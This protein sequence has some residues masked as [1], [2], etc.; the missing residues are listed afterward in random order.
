MKHVINCLSCFQRSPVMYLYQ[1]FFSQMFGSLGS[2]AGIWSVVNVPVWKNANSPAPF[3]FTRVG[4]GRK[5]NDQ[6][7]GLS[8]ATGLSMKLI[9]SVPAESVRLIDT[10]VASFVLNQLQLFSANHCTPPSKFPTQNI[11]V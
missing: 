6:S 5:P 8:S 1:L 2:G 7:I 4:V 10:A 3:G 9:V 11:K